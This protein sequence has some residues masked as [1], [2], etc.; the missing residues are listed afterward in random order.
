[1]EQP[2]KA[3]W[4]NNLLV[5]SKEAQLAEDFKVLFEKFDFNV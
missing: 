3:N 2:E 5:E 1:M 4:K